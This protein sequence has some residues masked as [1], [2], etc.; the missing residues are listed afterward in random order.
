MTPL[1]Q[2]E[3]EY[4]S[5]L[6]DAERREASLRAALAD[7]ERAASEVREHAHKEQSDQDVVVA[8]LRQQLAL[9]SAPFLSK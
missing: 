4:S 9:V 3:A 5:E 8:H 1:L 6:S 2:M 7:A